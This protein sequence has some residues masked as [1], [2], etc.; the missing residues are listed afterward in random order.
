MTQLEYNDENS[1]EFGGLDNNA[2]AGLDGYRKGGIVGFLIDKKIVKDE[3]GANIVLISI[4][5]ICLIAMAWMAMDIFGV[6]NSDQVEIS[7]YE[8]Q[9]L[10]QEVRDL[11]GKP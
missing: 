6:F 9:Q 2:F 1:S 10:P 8:L 11:L 3:K 4:A 5:V 7:E